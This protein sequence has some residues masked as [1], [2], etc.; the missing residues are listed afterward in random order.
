MTAAP[1]KSTQ[2][3][4]ENEPRI[5]LANIQG[6][7]V[8]GFRKP[9]QKFIYVHIDDTAAFK[10]A[11]AELGAR[12]AT[13][14]EVRVF[15]ERRRQA[16]PASLTST[17]LNVAFSFP[18]LQ[19]LTAKLNDCVYFNDSSF[20]GGFVGEQADAG[21]SSDWIV[22]DGDEAEAAHVLLVIGA[23]S[24]DD[25]NT[26]ATEVTDLITNHGA[27]VVGED[28]GESPPDPKAVR[29]HFGFRDGISQPGLRG[30][31]EADPTQLL[32]PRENPDEPHQGKPGQELIW[33]GEFVFGHPSQAGSPDGYLSGGDSRYGGAGNALV[34][35][36]GKDGS[37]LVFRRL[38]QDV[39]Q[40]HQFLKAE[41]ERRGISAEAVGAQ[42]VG[43]WRS[44]APIMRA[45][46]A[47][48]PTLGL[49]DC[50]NNLFRFR[51]KT[52]PIVTHRAG[53]C[54]PDGFPS[55]PADPNGQ[56]CPVTAHIRTTN[57]RDAVA[58]AEQRNHRMLRRGIAFGKPSP[59]TP[60]A[61]KEDGVERG[62]LFLAC[63][64]S[65]TRQF[66]FIVERWVGNTPRRLQG[67]GP[68]ALLGPSWIETTGGGN[69][70]APS[71]SALREQLSQ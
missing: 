64:T 50:A 33:P 39:F 30:C 65:I 15:A 67:I 43:R 51:N 21:N 4:D 28:E 62:L 35:E 16:R 36:W 29:E 6:N 8:P 22:K 60:N 54:P 37:Y 70:F 11:V 13:A 45:P 63:M 55:A 17:W 71:L 23:D 1:S 2:P 12:V 49:D 5:D 40:F 14:E 32:T 19:K 44:G 20:R 38:R 47:D 69:Y 61:P 66:H 53:L 57:P 18:A 7:I 59:S 25:V 58:A 68:D 52:D 27:R 3:A 42:L 24:R 26:G 46:D 31:A 41:G 9:Y 48:D 10:P 56:V 34:P